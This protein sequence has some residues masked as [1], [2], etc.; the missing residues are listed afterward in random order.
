MKKLI[1]FLLASTIVCFI[2]ITFTFGQVEHNYSVASGYTNCDSLDL[3]GIEKK[4]VLKLLEQS[5]FRFRQEFKLTRQ[6]G[7]KGAAYYSCDGERGYL[8]VFYHD[9]SYLFKN[10]TKEIWIGFSKSSDPE[11]F[12]TKQI[13]SKISLYE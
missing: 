9:H 7:L 10:V 4:E 11:G 12:F 2:P 13:L 8:A 1:I 6:E 3:K 5:S